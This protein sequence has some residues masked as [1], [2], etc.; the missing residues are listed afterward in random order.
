MSNLINYRIVPPPANTN[1]DIKRTHKS[2]LETLTKPLKFE[3]NEACSG[4]GWKRKIRVKK[5]S[6]VLVI[7]IDY[8]YL[9]YMI[10]NCFMS[11]VISFE[12][13]KKLR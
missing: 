7:F 12:V 11:H 2:A 1:E 13:N 4:R 10:F 8:V 5:S 3:M 6:I 9:S